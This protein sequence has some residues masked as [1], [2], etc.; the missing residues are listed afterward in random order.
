MNAPD[1]DLQRWQSLWQRL[2]VQPPQDAFEHLQ[3]LYAGPAR[4]YHSAAHIDAMLQTFDTLRDHAQAPELLELAIWYHDAIYDPSRQ[5]NES[6]SAELA[7]Q[8][9]KASG[10][11][12]QVQTVHELIM[13]TDH[14]QPATSADQRLL[15]DIDL[16]ILAATPSEYSAYAKA[17]RLEYG[18]F[19]DA[20]YVP[21]RVAVL[22]KFLQRPV[23]FTSPAGQAR[24]EAR[25]RENIQAEIDG[26]QEQC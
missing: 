21:G 8:V 9:L 24:W 10:L 2:G 12:T 15:V 7:S 4:H 17:V 25:A 20:L 23:I 11:G 26:L 22:K 3:R 18:C 1:L 16:S 19:P 14:R 5:D 13:A 6:R